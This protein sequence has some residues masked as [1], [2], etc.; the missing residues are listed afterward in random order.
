MRLT[1][2]TP[3]QV[4]NTRAV[5]EDNL[6][7]ELVAGTETVPVARGTDGTWS[8]SLRLPPTGSVDIVANWFEEVNVTGSD[9]LV[10]VSEDIQL[11]RSDPVSVSAGS[12]QTVR[13]D[14]SRYRSAEF[15][16]DNDVTDNLTERRGGSP[17]LDPREPPS[18]DHDCRRSRFDGLS[19][20]EPQI[21]FLRFGTTRIDLSEDTQLITLDTG[22]TVRAYVGSVALFTRRTLTVMHFS[23][24][25]ADTRV[26]LYRTAGANGELS[27]F[28]DPPGARANLRLEVE[29]GVYCFILYAGD[30]STDR[31]LGPGQLNTFSS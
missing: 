2:P 14:A 23:G 9:G 11:V 4:F 29:P 16:Y 20:P 25:P 7:L 22:E 28:S 30:L 26:E 21:V 3:D 19:F 31:N 17:A 6:R 8:T 13:I 18:I 15:D 1:L 24:E 12:N 27:R 5:V 10:F